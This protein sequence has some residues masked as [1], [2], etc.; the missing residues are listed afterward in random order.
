MIILFLEIVKPLGLVFTK[1]ELESEK[2]H[3]HIAG[4]LGQELCA[5]AV[6]VPDGNELKMQRVAT[7]V[8]LQ[9]KGIGSALTCFCE[10]YA[11]KNGYQSIYCHARG[12]AIAFYLKNRYVLENDPF[13]EDGISHHKMRKAIP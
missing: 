8:S 12:T 11:E 13:D 3:I 10:D 1:D 2:K 5:T 7:K 4:F 9:G 6:L